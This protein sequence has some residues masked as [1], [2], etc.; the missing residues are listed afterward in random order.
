MILRLNDRSLPLSPVFLRCI[1]FED[2]VL[3][4]SVERY[5][6]IQQQVGEGFFKRLTKKPVL[7][8]VELTGLHLIRFVSGLSPLFSSC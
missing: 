1:S 7:W 4:R 3:A 6:Y 2:S 5:I 8:P